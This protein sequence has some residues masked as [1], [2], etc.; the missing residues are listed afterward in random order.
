MSQR[1]G[2]RVAWSLAV[3][4]IVIAIPTMVLMVLGV[5]KSTPGDTFV[6]GGFGGVAFLLASLAFAVVGALA[7]SRVRGNPIGWIFCVVGLILGLGDF[8]YQ[9]ADY[10][11]YGAPGSLPGGVVAAWLN[12]LGVPPAFGLV[13]LSLLL[14]PNGQLLSHR[15]RPALW[16][17]I[18]GIICILG[19]A[20]RPGR[21]DWPFSSVSNPLG[22]PGGYDFLN[23]ATTLGWPL[24]AATAGLAGLAM[25]LRLRRSHGDQRQQVKWMALAAALGGVVT[26]ANVASFFLAV[27][28]LGPL[29][30]VALGLV[31]AIVPVAAGIAILRYRLYDV[32]VVINRT[33]VYGGLTATLGLTYLGSVLLLQLALSRVTGGSSLAV[34]GSTLGVAALFQPARRRIQQTVDRRFYRRKYDAQRTLDDFSARL[35]EQVDFGSLNT[36]LLDIVDQTMQPAHV[37]LWL[38][39]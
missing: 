38:R 7:V 5:G 20:V 13:A 9:Y 31:F 18:S 36:E 28:G 15:W 27:E 8:A 11:L 23:A 6:Q 39:G 35:R 14:F 4:C 19:Y 12:Q 33:L 34:A 25:A 17:G 37:S 2:S 10:A 26:V 3:A 1:I 32:D 16:L 21:F 24:M 22:I 29:R 30:S